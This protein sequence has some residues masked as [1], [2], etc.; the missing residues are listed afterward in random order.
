MHSRRFP[1]EFYLIM[2]MYVLYNVGESANR[3]VNPLKRS[4]V[5]CL[6]FEVFSAVQ[7]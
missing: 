4:G 1:V 6:Y 5:R 7:V 3:S 2:F